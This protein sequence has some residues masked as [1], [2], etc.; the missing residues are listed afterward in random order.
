MDAD[1]FLKKHGDKRGL[2]LVSNADSKRGPFWTKLGVGAPFRRRFETMGSA[3]PNSFKVQA[4]LQV[5]DA[6]P[7]GWSSRAATDGDRDAVRKAAQRTHKREKAAHD[8]LAAAP[9]IV[10]HQRHT[11]RTSRP[12]RTEWFRPP[13]GPGDAQFV[14]NVI[15]HSFRPL[16]TAHRDSKLWLCDRFDCRRG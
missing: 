6:R 1:E 11:G 16:A 12:N 10:R 4:F 14:R 8:L 9:G 15:A 7:E 5:P 2:Y 13:A 3:L